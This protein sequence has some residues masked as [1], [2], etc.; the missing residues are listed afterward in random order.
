VA[1]CARDEKNGVLA[2]EGTVTAHHKS[3]THNKYL[4]LQL[5]HTTH[6]NAE[7]RR[8]Q[9]QNTLFGEIDAHHTVESQDTAHKAGCS[10]EVASAQVSHQ[11]LCGQV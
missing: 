10:V 2:Y 5:K 8:A 1:A 7:V 6:H 11:A 4:L 3:E 9:A